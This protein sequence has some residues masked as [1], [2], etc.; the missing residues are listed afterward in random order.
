MN[1]GKM[2][3]RLDAVNAAAPAAQ[4]AA[5]VALRFFRRDIF[6]LHDRLEQNGLALFETV[7]HGKNRRQLERELIRIDFVEASVNDVHFNID[8]RITPEHAVQNRFVDPLLDRWDVFTR[9]NA[10]DD[11]V[12]DYQSSTAA[13]WTQVNLN[14][15]VLTATAGLLDQ[16]PHAVRVRRD[17]FTIGDLR[18]AGVRVHFKFATACFANLK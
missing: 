3:A 12:F 14:V 7:F 17:R 2:S 9:N 1:D 4:V 10:A 18:F 8:N 11:L 5:D 6:D 15:A 13:A 16:F